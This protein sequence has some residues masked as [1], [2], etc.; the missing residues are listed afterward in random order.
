MINYETKSV[1]LEIED[2]SIIRLS[3]ADQQRFAK[4]LLYP[5]PPVPALEWAKQAHAQLIL[6]QPD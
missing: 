1:P 5:P 3:I 6:S 2:L 4:L